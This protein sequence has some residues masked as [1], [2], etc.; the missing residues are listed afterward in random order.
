MP[1]TKPAS[2]FWLALILLL[3]LASFTLPFTLFRHVDAWYGSFLFWSL[4]TAIVIAISAIIS[5]RW[6]D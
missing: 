1:A 3:V 6:K 5:S 2:K 4:T